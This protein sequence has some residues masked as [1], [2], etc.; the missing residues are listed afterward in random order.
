MMS[1]PLFH[2][3]PENSRALFIRIRNLGE[4]VLDTANL[5]ALKHFRPD[6]RIA[7]LVE[8]TYADLYAADLRLKLSRCPKA[9]KTVAVRWPRV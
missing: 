9:K 7:T 6:L 4:A 5:R 2:R 1:D 8:A 3:L